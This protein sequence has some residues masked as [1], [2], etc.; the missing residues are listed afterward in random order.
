[1]RRCSIG[2][3]RCTANSRANAGRGSR[4]R[5]FEQFMAEL[6]AL[7][8]D[9]RETGERGRRVCARASWRWASCSPPSLGSRYLNAQGVAPRGSMRANVLRAVGAAGASEKAIICRRPAISHPTPRCRGDW[10]ALG[11]WCITQGFIASNEAGETVLLGRGGSDTSGAYFAAKLAALRLEIWT[12]VPGM[13]SANPRA[14][15]TARLLRCAALRRGPGDREQRR[16][17]PASALRAA[18]AP[19]RDSAARLCDPGAGSGRHRGLARTSRTA[20]RRSRRSPSRRASRWC[21]WTARHVAPGRLSRRRLPGLQAAGHV[22]GSDLH[23]GN[24]RH[25]I[26]GSERQHPGSGRPRALD[27]GARRAVSR[28]DLGTLRLA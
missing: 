28:R 20:R 17:G 16:Q 7:A 1:M 11:A 27:G 10:R 15:P 24:Q 18:G 8:G 13:F 19:V 25:R 5:A 26:A 14:V 22:G 2:S 21:P 3:K 6:N 9:A 23:L 12:D 4:M